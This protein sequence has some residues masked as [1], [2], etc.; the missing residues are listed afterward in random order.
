MTWSET[1]VL[2]S[3][4]WFSLLFFCSTELCS[5]LILF[6]FSYLLPAP[7]ASPSVFH[8]TGEERT[9][10]AFLLLPHVFSAVWIV[11]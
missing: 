5:D 10:K 11:L 3:L 7:S 2:A 1:P 6:P 4:V 9:L 8:V